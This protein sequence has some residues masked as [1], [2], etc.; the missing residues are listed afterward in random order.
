MEKIGLAT[1]QEVD[2]DTLEERLSEAVAAAQAQVLGP[3]QFCGW[4]RC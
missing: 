4:S 2:V 3:M 1:A